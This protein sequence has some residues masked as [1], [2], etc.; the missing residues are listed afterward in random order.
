MN[1]YDHLTDKAFDLLSAS[2][3][4]RIKYVNTDKW[5]EYPRAKEIMDRLDDLMLYPKTE[6]MPNLLIAG[7]SNSGKSKLLSQWS[8]KF[9]VEVDEE[10][11]EINFPIVM[12]SAPPKPDD[13]AFFMRVLRELMIPHAKNDSTSTLYEKAIRTMIARNTKMLII[14]EIQHAI[15][16]S[17]VSQTVFLDTIK[18]MGNNLQIPIVA[19]GVED[20]FHALQIND[21]LSNRFP[22]E[23]LEQWQFDNRESR[24]A[25]AQLVLTVESMLPLPEPSYLYKMPF[26]ER[27][28]FLSDGL[29][30]E[31]VGVIRTLARYAIKHDLPC[32]DESVFANVNLSPPSQR[33]EALKKLR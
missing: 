16:G 7:R 29:L 23:V 19:A 13:K 17:Y 15:A 31:V 21:Q 24:R 32:I 9:P 5:I 1:K 11:S 14:D 20:A 28:H 18:D 25:F 33:K 8:K 6:R 4:E 30:G 2:K 22:V 10:T 26:V 12:I 3:E 27:I